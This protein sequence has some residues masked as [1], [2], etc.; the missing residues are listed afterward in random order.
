[1]KIVIYGATGMVGSQI[2][3]Q[4]VAR[5]HEV[6][7]VSRSG[8]PVEGTTSVAADLTDTDRVVEL[9][10]AADA[11]VFAV[12]TDRTGGP[13][14][15]VVDAHRRIIAARPAARL[16]VVGGAGSLQSEGGLLVDGPEFPDAYKGEARAFTTILGDYRSSDGLSWTLVSPSPVIAPGDEKG[17][18]LGTDSPAGD[19]V[20]TGD[21]AA[22]VLDELEKPTYVGRRF[23]VASRG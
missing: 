12:P 20:T 22:A 8:A 11:V 2:A 7:A 1:M 13:A 3:Q 17:Y 14:Q 18:V 5:G 21:F 10:Q 6:T 9:A 4:A 19:F 15:P 16:L 23:T